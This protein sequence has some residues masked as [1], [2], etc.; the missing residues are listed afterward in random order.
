MEG[1]GGGVSVWGA[2][3]HCGEI[4]LGQEGLAEKVILHLNIKNEPVAWRS[5]PLMSVLRDG[6]RTGHSTRRSLEEFV[7]MYVQRVVL[8]WFSA[9]G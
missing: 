6:E 3:V 5:S 2:G 7:L 1:D 4:H 9:G 8:G